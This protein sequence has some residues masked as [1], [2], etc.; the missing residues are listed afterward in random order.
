MAHDQQQTFFQSVKNRF[1]HLFTDVR[2]LDIGSLDINGNTRH[3][4]QQPYYYIGLD[5]A[6]GPN[7]D[8]VC[9]AH[10]YDCGFKFDVVIS[11]EC[12][13][14]DMYYARSL[15]NMVNLLKSGGLMV[16]TCASD[17]RPE[18]GTLRTTPENAPFLSQFSEEWG[19][20]YK[21]LNESDIRKVLDINNLFSLFE[22]QYNPETCDLYFWGIKK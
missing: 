18:H 9:P 15:N 3:F 16:F 12:F 2:V 4:F 14:H 17:G 10:L 22:F 7:V 8:V 11:G 19:N 5:L 1:P 13:E 20:Y 6:E 21:N